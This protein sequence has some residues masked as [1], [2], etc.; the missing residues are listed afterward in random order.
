MSDQ[1]EIFRAIREH[2]QGEKAKRRGDAP[3][4]LTQH[5]V[6]FRSYNDG[7]HL[8][9]RGFVDFYPGTGLWRSR[10]T[11]ER[12]RGIFDLLRFLGVPTEAR[13]VIE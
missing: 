9:V 3:K 5:D 13:D 2:E 8:F 10:A 7:V 6:G 12:G 1:V 4:I 11:G